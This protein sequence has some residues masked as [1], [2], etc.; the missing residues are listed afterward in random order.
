MPIFNLTAG[1]RGATRLA[2]GPVDF[3][4][5]LAALDHAFGA[6]LLAYCLMHTHVHA[7]VEGELAA[8]MRAMRLALRGY[9]RKR[10][11]REAFPEM[12]RGAIDA[13][14][15]ADVLELERSIDYIHMNPVKAKMV[16]RAIFYE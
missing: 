2:H 4:Y 5:L 9:S 7:L 12:L 3:H 14:R 11:R 13:R 16:E 8:V 1:A 15:V 10:D 6:A